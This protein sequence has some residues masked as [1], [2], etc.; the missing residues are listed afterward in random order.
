MPRGTM[1][2]MASIHLIVGY[3]GFGK[4][5][6]ARRLQRELPAVRL[7]H[8]ELMRKLYGRDLP[9]NEFRHAWTRVDELIWQ[10]AEQVAAAGV[11]VVLDY[12]F[13]SREARRRAYERARNLTEDVVFH[14]LRCDREA[15]LARVLA[16]NAEDDDSLLI[17]RACFE[18]FWPQ[19]EEIS[20]AENYPVVK[21]YDTNLW[22]KK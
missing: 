15:A 13:W 4:T 9:E 21:F 3:M 12:G 1:V 16:R 11:D 2:K 17:D 18:R 20:S 19:Y 8:D 10:L 14:Q 7:T 6:L 5:F 22:G